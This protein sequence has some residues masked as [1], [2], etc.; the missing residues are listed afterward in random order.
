MYVYV[1]VCVCARIR[2]RERE[3]KIK[4]LRKSK[5]WS[6]E[7]YNSLITPKA[8]L[9]SLFA[10]SSTFFLFLDF[11]VF[12]KFPL[13]CIFSF[14]KCIFRETWCKGER[15]KK[16]LSFSIPFFHFLC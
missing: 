5:I 15:E 9:T 7:F 1:C 16:F 8:P 10:F 2:E 13:F 6:R 3:S 12:V 11:F 14:F 4:Q